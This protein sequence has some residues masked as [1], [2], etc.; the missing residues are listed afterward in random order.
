MAKTLF[1]T[2]PMMR[3]PEVEKAQKLLQK[4]HFNQDYLQGKVDGQFGPETARACKR[5]KYWLGYVRTDGDYGIFLENYLNGK[6]D[7]TPPMLLRRKERLK[8]AA[9]EPLRLKAMKKA[10]LDIGIKEHPPNSNRCEISLWWNMIGPWCAMGVS[11]WYI[12]A[13][14]KAFIKG[15]DWAYVPWLVQAAQQGV[16][17]LALTRTPQPGDIVCFDWDDD[18]VAD[19]TGIVT[20]TVTAAGN[21]K[22]IEGNTSFGNDSNGGECMRRERNT[23]DVAKAGS[24]QLA[25]I[26]VSK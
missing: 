6:K 11:R 14:S 17:G 12:F 26:H 8:K 16:R 10:E 3:G 5:A 20:T 15:R 7:I 9:A 23:K 13:G 18:G 2:S 19:H 4:N 21:F 1:L 22:T 24:G 25:F